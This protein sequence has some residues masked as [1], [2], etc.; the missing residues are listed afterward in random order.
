MRRLDAGDEPH[1]SAGRVVGEAQVV[2]GLGQEPASR[3]GIRSVVEERG[4]GEH[5]LLVDGT[6]TADF[7]LHRSGCRMALVV[8]R[9]AVIR[10]LMPGRPRGDEGVELRADAGLAV[11]RPKANRDFFALRPFRAEQARA[12]YRAKGLHAAVVRPEDADQLLTGKQAEPRTRDAS[13]RS[14]KGARVLSAS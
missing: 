12:A 7:D 2:G 4:G 8:V 9:E 3:V 11:E 1:R 13:L 5:G 6:E 14:A 10:D